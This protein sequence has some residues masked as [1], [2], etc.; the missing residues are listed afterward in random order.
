M[1]RQDTKTKDATGFR[2]SRTQTAK[3]TIRR[4]ADKT[5]DAIGPQGHQDTNNQGHPETS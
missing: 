3:D 4:Q 2:D 1:R 5:K